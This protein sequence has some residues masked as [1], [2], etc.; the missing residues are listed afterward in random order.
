MSSRAA[1]KAL[2]K[3]EKTINPLA[4]ELDIHPS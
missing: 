1:I 2:L 4:A 3:A